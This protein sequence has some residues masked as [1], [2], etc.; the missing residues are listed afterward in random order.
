MPIPLVRSKLVTALAKAAG[1]RGM[2]GGQMI[3]MLGEEREFDLGA[4]TRSQRMKTGE[5]F[6]FACESGA[7]LGRVDAARRQ[8]LHAYRPR[9][10][11][12]LSDHRPSAG[13]RAPVKGEKT[14]SD[15]EAL[16]LPERPHS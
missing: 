15:D 6:A 2:I 8:A 3:D 9:S 10:G 11:P 14:A 1:G 13:R 12:G 7:I 5:L 16:V 4:V